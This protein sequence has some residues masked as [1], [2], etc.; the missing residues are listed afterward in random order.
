M[1]TRK[2]LNQLNV[3]D[4]ALFSQFRVN[5]SKLHRFSLDLYTNVDPN[6]ELV[7]LFDFDCSLV[8]ARLFGFGYYFLFSFAFYSRSLCG[9]SAHIL[10]NRS[11]KLH[12]S[13]PESWFTHVKHHEYLYDIASFACTD[14]Y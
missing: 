2:C 10:C 5:A 1:K 12:H 7:V 4:C 11:R 14:A 8:D 13:K 6:N 9:K 3:Y